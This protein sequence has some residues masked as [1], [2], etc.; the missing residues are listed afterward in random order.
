LLI[1]CANVSS[2]LLARATGRARET[3]VRAALGAGRGRLARTALLESLVLALAG[4]A[5]GLALAAWALPALV[6]ASPR[7]LSGLGPGLGEIG[8]GA[9]SFAVAFAA[10]A[11]AA[12]LAGLVPALRAAR[13]AP[14]EV[15][16]EG[17]PGGGSLRGSR[18]LAT[19]VM[20]EVA[21]CLP[22]LAGAL[23]LA[24]SLAGLSAVPLG[25]DPQG[26]LTLRIELS[27]KK[28]EQVL[29]FHER[30]L[31]DLRASSE[32]Q[33]VGIT[34]SLPLTGLF[35]L[36]MGMT[37]EHAGAPEDVTA[38]ARLVS[39]GYFE[40]LR[41]PR[42][43][44]RAL[45]PADR[46]GAP[47][48]A[49]VNQTFARTVWP[50]ESPLGKRLT[51]EG[52][53]D[54]LEVVGV[55]GDVRHEGPA[56]ESGPEVFLPI[57]QSPVPFATVVIRGRGAPEALVDRVRAV[58]REIDPNVAAKS[59]RPME[60]VTRLALAGPRF[61]AVLAGVLA[62]AAL[63]LAAAGLYGVTAYAVSR[64]TREIGLR[65]ALGASRPAVLGLVL[66]RALLPVLAGAFI[67]LAAAVP[68]T[69][70]LAGLLVQV[71]PADPVVLTVAAL[72]PL[73]VALLAAWLPARRAA[74]VEP[75]A[76]LRRD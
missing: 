75:M 3:A 19:W 33:A 17:S 49:L 71:S 70:L 25:L 62:L 29:A 60:A 39:P 16:Q 54:S 34:S 37:A 53:G 66:R 22:L 44:G 64:R 74:A 38:G 7:G 67:G 11:G 41:I 15:L 59:V 14:A 48:V 5:L 8:L 46:D 21:L 20:A 26:V 32:V 13:S 72:V 12:V 10:C 51:L 47:A 40:V 52:S 50:G 9:R 36:Q 23:L 43:A 73:A 28:T 68:L 61:H 76:A 24:K 30:F 56:A 2:L 35:D 55:V 42:I 69:R 6:A 45:G 31:A 65:M 63:V 27:G 4:G 57:A 1:A 18:L 58:L